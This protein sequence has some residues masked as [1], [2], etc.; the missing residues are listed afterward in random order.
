VTGA[1]P[2]LVARAALEVAAHRVAHGDRVLIVDGSPK[3]RLHER[4]GR[5][6]RWG[7]LECLAA[8][9]PVLGLVQYGGPSRALPAAARQRRPLGGLVI[10]WAEAG[11][12]P[13]ELQPHHPRGGPDGPD[14]AGR[15]AARPG[16]GGLVGGHGAPD[17]HAC[18][19]TPWGGLG[20][21]LNP[22][23]PIGHAGS[24]T[25]S[26]VHTRPGA[27][28]P[29]GPAAELAPI[30]APVPVIVPAPRPAVLEPI[31]LD[32]DLQVRQRL[33]FLA[34]MRR[35]QAEDQREGARVTS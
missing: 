29:A 3:L 26:H 7:L 20:I 15:R 9:M 17:A 16:H 4:L 2:A 33:R 24:D 23:R 21:A 22:L 18:P 13:A 35:V 34:W 11:R 1:K 8:E 14:H 5:D 6:A 30:T 25:R 27:S 10:A 12:T 31:V 19:R 32:C 28:A